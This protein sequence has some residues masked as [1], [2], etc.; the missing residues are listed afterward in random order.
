[1]REFLFIIVIVC[2]VVFF[3]C[4][5]RSENG[6]NANENTFDQAVLG[7]ETAANFVKEYK[8][9]LKCNQV[10]MWRYGNNGEGFIIEV[11]GFDISLESAIK[12]LLVDIYG[13]W[14]IWADTENGVLHITN[15]STHSYIYSWINFNIA[16]WDE[17]GRKHPDWK[18]EWKFPSKSV[19]YV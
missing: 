10:T 2:F 7:I 16:V 5:N 4:R 6:E 1:M 15:T 14:E 18:I 12:K 17:V 9:L 19:L 8:S 13:S 3:I 11:Y